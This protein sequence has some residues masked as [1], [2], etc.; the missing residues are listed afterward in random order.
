MPAGS[1]YGPEAA[2]LDVASASPRWGVCRPGPARRAPERP[3]RFWDASAVVPMLVAESTTTAMV[4]FATTD[5]EMLVWWATEVE[6]ASAVARLE[7]DGAL[8]AAGCRRSVRPAAAACAQ[9][10]RGRAWRRRSR[11]RRPVPPRAPAAGRRRAAVGGGLRRVRGATVV[12]DPHHPRRP[13]RLGRASGGFHDRRPA[14][15]AV[16]GMAALR[17]CLHPR[18]THDDGSARH[19]IFLARPLADPCIVRG[20]DLARRASPGD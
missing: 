18:R 13:P 8:G 14:R 6:C 9:L 1:R 20:G 19:S 11:G 4:S 10:A 16:N 12:T 2:V 17:A 7:R 5:P 3:V 15:G